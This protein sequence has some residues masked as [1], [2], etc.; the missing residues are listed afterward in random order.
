MTE[1]VEVLI[2]EDNPHDLEMA[3]RA[4][5][6][7]NLANKVMTLSDGASALDFIFGRGEFEG[8]DPNHTPKVVFLD[9]KIPKVD[10]VEVLRQ[11]K[12]SP[13]TKMIPVVILTSS[14][15]DRDRIES[16][17]LGVNSYVVKPIDFDSFA[18]TIADLGF[19]WLAVNRPPGGRS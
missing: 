19:Y 11:M 1:E 8:R 4:L 7:H 9:L 3:I 15:E 5:R 6:A 18:K 16:Y 2:V 12:S 13:L 14:A 17:E 10:G